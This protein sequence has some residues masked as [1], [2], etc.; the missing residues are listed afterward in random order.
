NASLLDEAT[1]A[2]EAMVMFF[3][4]RK[5]VKEHSK[6]FF[7]SED[8]FPQ[9]I[10]VIKSRAKGFG[11]E[12]VIGDHNIISLTDEYFGLLVQYPSNTGKVN[13]YSE[14]FSSADDNRIYKIV[15]AD[16][17]SLT[18]L[19]PP[20]EFGADAAVGTTQRFGVPMG[21]GGPH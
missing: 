5:K 13:D 16:L 14:L 6:K 9:T 8:V 20:G 12:L 19:K 3:N 21:Y 4:T 10:D 17:L 7:I 15:A 2:A 11:I 18:L 1:A